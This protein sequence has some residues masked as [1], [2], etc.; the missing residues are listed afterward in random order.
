MGVG[1]Y[2]LHIFEGFEPFEHCFRLSLPSDY[3]LATIQDGASIQFVEQV[4][5]LGELFSVHNVNQLGAGHVGEP[6]RVATSEEVSF[7]LFVGVALQ[8]ACKRE[9]IAFHAEAIFGNIA[10][11]V[12]G[13]TVSFAELSGQLKIE[14]LLNP[15]TVVSVLGNLT[16]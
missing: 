14:V 15:L 4:E 1:S 12:E 9:M 13:Y 10:A 7:H 8:V 2:Q 3:Y 11:L 16:F 6:F 5:E